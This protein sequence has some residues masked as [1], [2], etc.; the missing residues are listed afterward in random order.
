[1]SCASLAAS[2]DAVQL[3]AQLDPLSF[4]RAFTPAPTV[5]RMNAL[6]FAPSGQIAPWRAKYG[7]A[8]VTLP[9][10]EKASGLYLKSRE[11]NMMTY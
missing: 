3:E 5:S 4:V 7:R 10:L 2:G 6:G 1:M 8:S 11:K 9:K